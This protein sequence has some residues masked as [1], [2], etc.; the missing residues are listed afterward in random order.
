MVNML[1]VIAPGLGRG[2]GFSEW[3]VLEWGRGNVR[4]TGDKGG[5]AKR[6]TIRSPRIL[7]CVHLVP[8][9]VSLPK[10]LHGKRKR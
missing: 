2:N 4:V 6:T 7:I 5:S 3:W 9:E 10:V 8:R 1:N